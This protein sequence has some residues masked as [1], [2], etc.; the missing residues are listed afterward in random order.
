MNILRNPDVGKTFIFELILSFAVG[1]TFF[2]LFGTLAA[3]LTVIL[4]LVFISAHLISSYRSLKKLRDLSEEVNRVLHGEFTMSLDHLS[5]GELGILQSEIY[6]M[7]V[8][9]REQQSRSQA[10]KIYLADSLA[11]ISHQIRTPLTSINLLLSLIFDPN[12][13][14]E[15]RQTLKG[16]LYE[17]LSRID[18]LITS[19][20]KISKLDAGTVTF[21]KEKLTLADLIDKACV[22][23]LIPLELKNI[24][25]KISADGNFEGDSLWTSEAVT[26]IVKNCM[27]HTPEGG[28]IRINA[29]ENALYSEIVISDSGTGIDKEDL[30]HIF[31]R[32]YKGKN[33][34]GKNF[35][36]G[37]ALAR[38]IIVSENGTIK[39]ENSINGGGAV[40]TVR[41]YKG[42]V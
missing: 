22:S 41:F 18:T 23:L 20:L 27:E 1:V 17:L 10:D 19:L 21:K 8:S 33:S 6:K 34:G 36:I 11:D 42:T 12:T 13:P 9:L 7:T 32:F 16:E 40:F 24:A 35:G 5:E 26:N 3:V 28:Y 25:T 31:E 15:R 4:C 14:E 39:A 37:L 30:P 2:L 38:M 29:S